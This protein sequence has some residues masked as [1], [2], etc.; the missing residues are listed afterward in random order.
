MKHPKGLINN[1]HLHGFVENVLKNREI[2][3]KYKLTKEQVKYILYKNKCSHKECSRC[4][5]PRSITQSII[6]FFGG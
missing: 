2:A 6:E 1:V 3:S 4:Y 5:K